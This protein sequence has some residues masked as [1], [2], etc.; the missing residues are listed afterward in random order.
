MAARR[1]E[2]EKR[3]PCQDFALGG[4]SRRKGAGCPPTNFV[5]FKS[6]RP[7]SPERIARGFDAVQKAALPAPG[8]GVS[9]D[10]MPRVVKRYSNRKLYDTN[11]SRYVALDDIAAMV[12][13][14]EEVEVTDNETGADL[15]AV[16][17]AQIILE[18]ER[19]RTGVLSLNLLRDL[20]R[21]GGTTIADVTA[22]GLETLGEIREAAGRRVAE[23]VNES[24]VG[25]ALDE[26]FT[27]SRRRIDDLQR[28]IDTGIKTSLDTLR[29][30]PSIGPELERV[31]GGLRDIE[32]RL[33]NL[34]STVS[35]AAKDAGKGDDDSVRRG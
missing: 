19:R 11:T 31:E 10:R 29:N 5:R 25:P 21:S 1:P 2:S 34:V 12:R 16:T 23:I 27:G 30:H 8:E 26:V 3:P 33:K 14:G 28:R 18:D 17:L 4:L 7:F 6:A 15:T 13:R 22:R 24:P 35:D 9:D 20:V 32:A